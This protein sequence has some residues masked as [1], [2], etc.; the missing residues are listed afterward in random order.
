MYDR[1]IL[2]DFRTEIAAL[3][4]TGRLPSDGMYIVNRG[5]TSRDVAVQTEVN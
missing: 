4:S 1:R 2:L 5:R 3:I